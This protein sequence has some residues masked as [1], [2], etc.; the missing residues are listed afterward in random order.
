MNALQSEP[1]TALYEADETAWLDAMAE[2][3]AQGRF[4]ELDQIH[5]AEYLSD[6]AKRDRREVSSRPAQLLAHLLKWYFQ[7]VKRTRSRE[8]SIELQRQKLQQILDS[9]TLRNHAEDH[10]AEIYA[11]AIRLVIIDTGLPVE[12]FPP[13]R[14]FDWP[15]IESAPLPRATA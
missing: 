8:R 1:L 14:P 4:A 3:V 2:L 9:A 15:Q 13:V 6:M 11:K 10:L 5:L 12:A 7:P